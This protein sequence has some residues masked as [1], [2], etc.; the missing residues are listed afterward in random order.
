[1]TAVTGRRGLLARLLCD[2]VVVSELFTDPPGVVLFP[3]EAEIGV[4]AVGA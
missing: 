1:M 4:A 2:A 3:Q